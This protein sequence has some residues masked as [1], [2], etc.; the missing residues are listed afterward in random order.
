MATRNSIIRKTIEVGSS[1]MVSR[2]LGMVREILMANYLGA[3]ILADA[4]VTAFK[5]PNSLRKIFAEGALSASFVPTFVTLAKKDGKDAVNSLVTLALFL[6]EGVLLIVCLLVM[7]KAEFVIRCI[8]P[9]WFEGCHAPLPKPDSFFASVVSFMGSFFIGCQA[10]PQV[11]HAVTYLRI[12]MCFILFLS[13]SSLLAGAL[14]A[15]NHFFVPAF[16]PVLL[17][18]VFITGLIVCMSFSYS[19]AV[20]CIFIL[21]GGFLQLIWHIYTYFSY[22][23]HFG[24]IHKKT[25][26]TFTKVWKKFLPFLFS[27]SIVEIQLFIDTSFASYL[28]TGSIALIN[29]A[30]RF[31]QIPLGVFATA[32][33]TILLPHLSRVGNYAPRRLGFYVLEAS[34]LI[35]FVMIPFSLIM[36]FVA[37]KIFLTLF[38]SKKFTLDAVHTASLILIVSLGGLVFFSLNKILLNV[39]YALHETKLPMYISMISTLVNIILSYIL[40]TPFGVYGIAF[41]TTLAGVMQTVLFVF[42]LWRRFDLVCYPKQFKKFITGFCVQLGLFSLLFVSGYYGIEYMVHH[43]ALMHFLLYKMGFWLWF[44]PYAALFF[45]A[46][47]KTRK[48]FGLSFYFID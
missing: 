22:G 26:Q 38:L 44:V 23:F 36:G 42:F 25:W 37:E 17:N 6:F 41:A 47:F 35:F 7:W 2:L 15:V 34:K 29:Y 21:V 13:M 24:T 30:N 11:V 3:G 1:T 31:M 28:A 27:M 32:F 45:L 43:C 40:M 5:I 12:L 8:V 48:L 33:S 4:F 16:A 20:L 10:A 19:P 46:L 9:G 18:I 39:Y 14:Q